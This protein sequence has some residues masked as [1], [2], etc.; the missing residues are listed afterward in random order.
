MEFNDDFERRN[1]HDDLDELLDM[2]ESPSKK[3]VN[4]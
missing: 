1:I 4:F 2:Q 3:K